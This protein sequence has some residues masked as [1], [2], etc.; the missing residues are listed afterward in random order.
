ME[1]QNI[2]F[3][4]HLF[5]YIVIA[6]GPLTL[7]L[8]TI[9]FFTVSVNSAP[10]H[11]WIFVCQICSSSLYMRLLT[12]MGELKHLPKPL[13]QVFGTFYGI[14]NLDFFRSVYDPFC[15]H[16]G[17]TTLQVISLDYII[18]AYPLVTILVMYVLVHLYSQEYRPVVILWKPFH[19]CCTRFRHQLNIK[20]SLVDAFGTFFSLSYVKFLSTTVDLVIPTLVWNENGS[21]SY[22]SYTDGT[23]LYFRNDH[24]PFAVLSVVVFSVFNLLPLLLL[25]LYSFPKAQC[26]IHVIPQPLQNTLYPFMDNILSCYNDGTNGT[27]NCRW[28]GVVYHIARMLVWS[29]VM[30]TE[31]LLFFPIATVVVI[32]S[33]MF[34]TLVRPYKSAVYNALD[35]FLLLSL[36]LCVL[37]NSA[38]T[39]ATIDDPQ[40]IH[41]S[42]V[43][44]VVPLCIPLLYMFAY[45]GCEVNVVQRFI[46]NLN[47]KNTATAA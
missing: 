31:S 42:F 28:F 10:L 41:F 21:T 26:C 37:G 43:I 33:G 9:V 20:T 15:L 35:T 36:S 39:I 4:K 29:S 14:W 38:F 44:L 17:L 34:V 45:L 46:Q 19:Y 8:A 24:L 6:Y 30:W 7:F 32:I 2:T 11:G 16:P 13:Y 3:W 47:Y 1:C 5:L 27:K 12:R 18:A 40:N 25:L 22:H 23:Q